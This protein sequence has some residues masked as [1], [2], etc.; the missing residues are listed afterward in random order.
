MDVPRALE[1]CRSAVAAEPRNPRLHYQLARVLTYSGDADG[2]WRHR[3]IAAEAGYPSALF[4]IG[5]QKAFPPKGGP[6]EVC[7][8]ADLI[9]HSARAGAFA[10]QVGYVAAVLEGPFRPCTAPDE[11][12]ELRQF[13]DAARKGAD[14]YFETLLVKSLGRELDAW[15]PRNGGG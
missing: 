2:A 9:R 7:A 8:G 10:A 1:A 11:R 3:V 14:G 4:V 12:A 13:L 15:L 5:Y 6:A